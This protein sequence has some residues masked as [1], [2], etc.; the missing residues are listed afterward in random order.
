M[1]VNKDKFQAMVM[2]FDIK[3]NKH[4]LNINNSIISS[5]DSITV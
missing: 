1:I 2:S 4:H 5:V 3:E